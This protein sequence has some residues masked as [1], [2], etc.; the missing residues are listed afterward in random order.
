MDF[1]KESGYLR[2]F[3]LILPFFGPQ[4]YPLSILSS[5]KKKKKKKALS[6]NNKLAL[7][8][9]SLM[10]S[11]YRTLYRNGNEICIFVV[12]LFNLMVQIYLFSN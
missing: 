1:K 12:Q 7:V 2:N 6:S 3:L 11:I 5:L 4:Y 9:W 8:N 10:H